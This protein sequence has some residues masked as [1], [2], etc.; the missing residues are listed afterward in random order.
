[1][2]EHVDE[3][4]VSWEE[5][6]DI[7]LVV[8]RRM[9]DFAMGAHKSFFQG[10]GFDLVGLREWQP[11]DRPAA[12]DWPQSTLTNFSPLMTREFEE[13]STASVVIVAD[14][15]LSTGCGLKGTPIAKVIART[16]A[17]LSLAAAFC[18]DLVG[19][20]TMDGESRRLVVGPRRGRK[21]AI[22]CAEV[23][24]DCLAEGG[25]GREWEG[26]GDLSGLLRKRSLI[27][28]VSDFLTEDPESLMREFAELNGLHDVFVVAIDCAFAFRLPAVSAGWI[29]GYDVESGRSRVFSAQEVGHFEEHVRVWQSRSIDLARKH[30]LDVV[31]VMPGGEHHALS[32]FLNTRRLQKQ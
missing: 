1:M 13:E 12:V 2:S 28:I 14:T 25:R 23:Y 17:T 20:V 4:L 10:A 7:E 16:V 26:V 19:L 8:V 31:K 27:P 30:G 3:R 24:E 29:E 32:E 9:K 15:S 21:H 6:R 22:H 11:G 18:Q 5:I